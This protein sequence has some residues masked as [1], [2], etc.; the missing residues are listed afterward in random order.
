MKTF[1]WKVVPK[2]SQ[3]RFELDPVG[4]L[5]KKKTVIITEQTTKHNKHNM[6]HNKHNTK[7]NKQN[8]EHNKHNK[9]NT[10][11]NKHNQQNMYCR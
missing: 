4:K 8:T 11:H 1:P 7:H 6:R 5:C 2:L 9:Q 3:N 10:E